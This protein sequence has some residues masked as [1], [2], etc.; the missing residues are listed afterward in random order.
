MIGFKL[1]HI[2]SDRPMIESNAFL[3]RIPFGQIRRISAIDRELHPCANRMQ[4]ARWTGITH[5]GD[6]VHSRQQRND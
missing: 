5:L 6:A 3:R 2:P 1:A 4:P